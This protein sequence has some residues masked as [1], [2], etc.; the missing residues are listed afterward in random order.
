ATGAQRR[1]DTEA[2]EHLHD[3]P[4]ACACAVL[5]MRLH[6]GVR[7]PD[8]FVGDFVDAFVA[9]VARADRQLSA[10]LHIDDERDRDACRARPVRIGELTAVAAE[11]A[12]A[13]APLR[14]RS[15]DQPLS[16]QRR[17][18]TA[19]AAATNSS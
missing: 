10:L 19:C 9:V 17:V 1:A 16:A 6:A 12:R 5:E 4:V 8:D 2:L 13:Q 15:G 14:A 18:A 11:V 3:S 7:H